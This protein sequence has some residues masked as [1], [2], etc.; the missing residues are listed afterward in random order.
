MIVIDARGWEP[1]K[2]F[3]SVMSALGSLQP[4]DKLRLIVEREPLPLYRLLDRNGYAYF[5][6]V[7]T[8]GVYEVD[9]CERSP[10]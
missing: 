3:E 7:R 2:P 8:D 6:T 10:A 9:I 4:G 5:A 1:P